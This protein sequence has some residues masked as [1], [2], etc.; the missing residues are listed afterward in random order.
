ML[1]A[2]SGNETARHRGVVSVEF[3]LEVLSQNTEASITE[4]SGAGKLHAGIC[5]GVAE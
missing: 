4:E 2:L 3:E 1:G 5:T